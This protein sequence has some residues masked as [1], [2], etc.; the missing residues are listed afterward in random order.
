LFPLRFAAKAREFRE[1]QARIRDEVELKLLKLLTGVDRPDAIV[2]A[3][4]RSGQLD[5]TV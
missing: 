3:S 4:L 5:D 2:L 1:H